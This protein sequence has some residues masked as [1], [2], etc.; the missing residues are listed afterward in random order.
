MQKAKTRR[1]E[2]KT[3]PLPGL[4]LE[5]KPQRAEDRPSQPVFTADERKTAAW[6]DEATIHRLIDFFKGF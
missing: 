4:R 5:A 6:Q 3:E 2:Q 1:Y